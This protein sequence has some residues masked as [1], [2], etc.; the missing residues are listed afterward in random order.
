MIVYV[1]V[2]LPKIACSSIRFDGFD[3]STIP[4]PYWMIYVKA[5]SDR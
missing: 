1:I 2:A 4:T 3:R 5:E